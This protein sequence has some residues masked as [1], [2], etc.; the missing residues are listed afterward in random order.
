MQICPFTL[1]FEHGRYL[2]AAPVRMVHLCR[3][4]VGRLRPWVYFMPFASEV[5]GKR[6]L[7][8]PVNGTPVSL[9]LRL[10][11][12]RKR[13]KAASLFSGMVLWACE[14]D[15]LVP[16]MALRAY[17]KDRLVYAKVLRDHERVLWGRQRGLVLHRGAVLSVL[18]CSAS[19]AA[20]RRTLGR[21]WHLLR[22]AQRHS[23]NRRSWHPL[24]GALIRSSGRSWHLLWGSQRYSGGKAALRLLVLRN[25]ARLPIL[26]PLDHLLALRRSGRP[27]VSG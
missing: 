18:R 21:S 7:G 11:A 15:R 4:A 20:A 13:A 22:G 23:S 14:K 25:S 12:R 6:L 27:R 24:R 5:P 10:S 1:V 8:I 16:Q 19:D 26:P 9:R 2:I 3:L 17:E